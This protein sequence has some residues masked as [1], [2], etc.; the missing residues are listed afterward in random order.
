MSNLHDCLA[1]QALLLRSASSDIRYTSY[2]NEDD[3]PEHR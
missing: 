1:F 2:A 3:S